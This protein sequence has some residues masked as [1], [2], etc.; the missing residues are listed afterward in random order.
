MPGPGRG[1]RRLL[2][3][4]YLAGGVIAAGLLVVLLAV[5]VLQMVAR[6]FG[7]PF[8][9]SAEYAGY[10]MAGASFFAFAYTLNRGGHIRVGLLLGRLGRYRRIGEV[11]C[12]GVAAALCWYLAWY[13]VKAVSWSY[14]LGDVSQGQDRMLL[15]IPQ[16][17][18]A[19][20]TLLLAIAFTDNLVR[21]L[22]T[23][24]HGIVEQNTSE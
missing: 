8:R 16:L 6:W 12:F 17:S 24:R 22:A 7:F 4:L 10:A 19:A 15:W 13:A 20:G 3:G 21:L 9:G 18:I 14:R 1:V 2:D 23:G 5:I 11:W